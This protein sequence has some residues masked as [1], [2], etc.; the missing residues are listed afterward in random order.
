MAARDKVTGLTPK[1]E[2]FCVEFVRS[3]DG[4][5]T[6]AY[7]R[8]YGS[9]T[10]KNAAYHFPYRLR[11][12]PKICARIDQL[13]ANAVK[14]AELSIERVLEE[15][16]NSAF[17]DPIELFDAD[18]NL[19]AMNDIPEHARRAIAAFVVQPDGKVRVKFCDKLVALEKLM[20]FLGAFEKHNW[21]TRSP[22]DGMPPELVKEIQECLE[23]I[24]RQ[25]EAEQAADSGVEVDGRSAHQTA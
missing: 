18:G 21:Q 12:M 9:R 14:E 22:F 10:S 15:I 13:R 5:A 20:R 24:T 6:E 25:Y 7:R 16:R 8:V 2:Q 4:N 3:A 23:E 1:Q 19:R 17:I 11:R